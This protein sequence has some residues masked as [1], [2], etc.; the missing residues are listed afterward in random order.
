MSEQK[1]PLT[2]EERRIIHV[3]AKG[4]KDKLIALVHPRGSKEGDE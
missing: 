4:L 1:K 3:W 2:E